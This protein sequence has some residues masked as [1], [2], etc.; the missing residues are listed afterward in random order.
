MCKPTGVGN[1]SVVLRPSQNSGGGPVFGDYG[2]SELN[3]S[4]VE[5]DVRFG[6]QFRPRNEFS[7][8]TCAVTAP[9]VFD[10]PGTVLRNDLYVR[11]RDL[12]VIDA[13]FANLITPNG[14]RLAK[15]SLF[16]RPGCYELWNRLLRC[17]LGRSRFRPAIG[18]LN[19]CRVSFDSIG[20]KFIQPGEQR[21]DG[22][23]PKGCYDKPSNRFIRK[24]KGGKQFGRPQRGTPGRHGVDAGYPKYL[25]TFEFLKE[26]HALRAVKLSPKFGPVG[27]GDSNSNPI[28][29]S[30]ANCWG[31]LGL[32]FGRQPANQLGSS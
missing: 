21:N 32:A 6:R 11:A 1:F 4:L 19:I 29:V 7:I 10:I 9:K 20:S 22:Q 12:R 15:T 18:A 16:S 5:S 2:Q 8:E 30:V 28:F 27:V 25:A 23:E 31:Y 17:T 24:A 13:Q 3:S 26:C 14:E